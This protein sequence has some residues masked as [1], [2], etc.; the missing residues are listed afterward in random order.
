[1]R[2]NVAAYYGYYDNIQVTVVRLQQISPPPAPPQ[3]IS[4]SEN[5]AEGRVRGVDFDVTVVPT[6][7]LELGMSGAYN[8]NK[9]VSWPTVDANGN[10]VDRSDSRYLGNP[11]FKYN[12][13]ATVYL[14]IPEELGQLSVRADWQHQSRAW[15]DGTQVRAGQTPFSVWT[16]A[17]GYPAAWATGEVVGADSVNPHGT[18]DLS[19]TWDT[20]GGIEGLK[21]VATVTNVLKE[22]EVISAG[23]VWHTSGIIFGTARPPRMFT[24]GLNYSF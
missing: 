4:V 13:S 24:V 12:I 19:A 23:Y 3:N 18:L 6:Q 20:L 5:A 7:W 16:T 1:L 9:Y 10:P 17:N 14:P 21:G 2:S 8:A 15:Y 22:K 11:K